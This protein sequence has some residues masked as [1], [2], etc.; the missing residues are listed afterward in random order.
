MCDIALLSLN[1]IDYIS[2]SKIIIFSLNKNIS[3][4][5]HFEEK[6][7]IVSSTMHPNLYTTNHSHLNT[8][9]VN[10]VK[11]MTTYDG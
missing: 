5:L 7:V 6:K 11:L 8:Y 3:E 10:Y 2:N 9:Y 4:K 1:N